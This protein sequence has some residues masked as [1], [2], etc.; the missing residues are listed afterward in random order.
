MICEIKKYISKHTFP[1]RTSQPKNKKKIKY[2]D[3][4]FPTTR[5]TFFCQWRTLLLKLFSGLLRWPSRLV[6]FLWNVGE[7]TTQSN[8]ICTRTSTAAWQ[9]LVKLTRTHARRKKKDEKK[10]PFRSITQPS[11]RENC[12]FCDETFSTCSSKLRHERKHTGEMP[13]RC[14][15]CGSLF[16]RKDYL[17][18]HR[19]A[20][21][22]SNA[23]K[24]TQASPKYRCIRCGIWF[25]SKDL[26]AVHVCRKPRYP[27]LGLKVVKTKA[28]PRVHECPR[29]GEPGHSRQFCPKAKFLLL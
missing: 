3:S 27:P 20:W 4:S 11:L 12:R 22:S 16:Y 24:K 29:C 21:C 6:Y 2:S 8:W 15:A 18:K 17:K 19:L 9:F 5:L 10:R 28:Q 26:I 13:F 25:H 23:S 7:H 1:H 14:S